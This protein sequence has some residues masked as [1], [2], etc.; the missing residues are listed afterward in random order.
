L[1]LDC[2]AGSGTT[3]VEATVFNRR[4]IGMDDSFLALEAMLRRFAHGARPMGD[5]VNQPI[6][7]EYEQMDMFLQ[8]EREVENSSLEHTAL[9]DFTL[10]GSRPANLE[11]DQLIKTWQSWIREFCL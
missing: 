10:Y 8:N 2:F 4:W 11:V 3:L 5:F 6:I 1:V 9:T 7:A